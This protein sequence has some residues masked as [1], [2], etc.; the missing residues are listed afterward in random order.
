MVSKSE[1][2]GG[3]TLGIQTILHNSPAKIYLFQVNN[4]NTKKRRE[5]CSKL[6]I[7]PTERRQ[8]Q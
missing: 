8:R 6:I 5:I 7:K 3:K 1:R 4:G 2:I